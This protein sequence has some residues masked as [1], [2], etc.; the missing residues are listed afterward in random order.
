MKKNNNSSI[1]K[2][3]SLINQQFIDL[4]FNKDS[5]FAGFE[6]LMMSLIS[7]ISTARQKG[8]ETEDIR[9]ELFDVWRIHRESSFVRHIQTWPRGYPGDFE[10]INMIVDRHEKE[11]ANTLGGMIGR[12][13]LNSAIAQQHRE[14]IAI[15]A[16]EIANICHLFEVPRILSLAAGS[17]RDLEQVQGEVFSSEAEV[18]LVDFDQDALKESQ[19]RLM[20]INKQVSTCLLNIR[21][22]PKL[23][24]NLE[25]GSGGEKKYHLIYA[26]GLF[27]YLPTGIIKIILRS[28]TSFV[29]KKGVVMFTNI[30]LGNPYGPWME[31]MGKWTLIE[32]SEEEITELLACLT[33]LRHTQVEL[34]P[35]GLTWIAKAHF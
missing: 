26:G 5:D 17:S 21:K 30:A 18:L 9:A 16:T 1:G 32:R 25:N 13:A 20:N 22:L 35:T 2:L 23:L 24:K 8:W 15:Q 34:D 31:T 11:S 28:L 7:G 10:V 6:E 19:R 29:D 3:L 14:K 33:P 4:K 27:D 12:Y